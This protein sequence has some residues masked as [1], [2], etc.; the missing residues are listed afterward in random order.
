MFAVLLKRK[1]LRCL[2]CWE[3]GAVG[4][5][6]QP[7]NGYAEDGCASAWRCRLLGAMEQGVQR[8]G[9]RMCRRAGSLEMVRLR[10]VR[11]VYKGP[12]IS[13]FFYMES[14]GQGWC[15]TMGL[16]VLAAGLTIGSSAHSKEQRRDAAS[17]YEGIVT[18]AHIAVSRTLN[19]TLPIPRVCPCV[20]VIV[21]ASVS[22]DRRVRLSCALND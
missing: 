2:F 16:Q 4:M 18:V 21:I 17:D 15:L 11:R 13:G 10:F 7:S 9:F 3:L 14:S 22:I 20:S 5:D 1:E 6:Q 19:K 12:V 8:H